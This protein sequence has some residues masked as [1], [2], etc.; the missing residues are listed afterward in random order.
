MP[1]DPTVEALVDAA[2]LELRERMLRE[3]AEGPLTE[4]TLDQIETLVERLGREFRRDL[5]RRILAERTS[6]PRD[7]TVPCGCGER[8]RYRVR[9]ERVITT[10]HGAV[11]LLR[12][13]Y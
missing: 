10:R 9:R 4:G 2:L 8:A 6:G 7:N 12:P 11:H 3:L 13:Y 5:Q 1:P